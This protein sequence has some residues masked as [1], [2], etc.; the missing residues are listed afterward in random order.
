MAD[1]GATLAVVEK[2]GNLTFQCPILSTTNYPIWSLRIKAIF[3]AHGLWETIEP[4]I[5]VDPKKDN[6]AIAYLYQALLE[7]LILQVASCNTAREIWNSIKTRHLGVERVMEARLQSLRTEF[8]SIRMKEG[9]TVD[10]YVAKLLGIASKSATLGSAIEESSLVRKLL[11]S[12]PDNFLNMVAT[13][14]QLVDLKIVRFQEVVGRLKAY[15]ERSCP[16]SKASSSSQSQLL[17]TYEDWEAKRRTER[18]SGRG[19]GSNNDTRGRGRG[20]G[21]GRLGGRGRGAGRG[22]G[23]PNG[24]QNP[25]HQRKDRSQLQCFRC[26]A[27]GH[28]SADCPTRNQEELNQ[29]QANADKPALLMT[30]AFQDQKEMIYLTERKRADILTKAL[31][32]VKFEEMKELLGMTNLE[33]K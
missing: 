28:F 13:I 33:G 24:A 8:D 5:N 27:M 16:K 20:C 32:K 15:E 4:G 3:K 7:D 2:T 19:R 10:D 12:M 25:T 11:T 21:R 17:M 18:G 1:A 6:S 23:T 29:T 30:V 9:E 22:Q 14:E 26:D 31:P